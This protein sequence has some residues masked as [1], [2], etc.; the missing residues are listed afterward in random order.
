MVAHRNAAQAMPE[1][2]HGENALLGDSASEIAQLVAA[3]CA[4]TALRRRIGAAGYRTF[5]DSFTAERVA[6]KITAAC[7]DA[8]RA[9][10]A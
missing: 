6:P 5:R 8:L 2:V 7:R 3:A 9:K 10:A 4:D 1:I